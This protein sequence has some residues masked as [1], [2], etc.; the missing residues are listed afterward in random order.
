VSDRHD[1][2]RGSGEE[3]QQVAREAAAVMYQEGVDQYLEAKRIAARRI[4]GKDAGRFRPASLP[5][6][7]EIR[8]QLLALVR[9][10]EGPRQ[11]R[12]LFAMRVEA[13]V[14]MRALDAWH[15]RLLGSVWSGHVRRGS[16]IDLHVFGDLDAL[17]RDVGRLGWRATHEEVPIRV[18]GAIRLYHHLHVTDGPFPVELSV[19]APSER[20]EV[21]RSSVDGK[22]I[23]R[24]SA[25]RLA[26]RLRADSPDEFAAW[27][28]DGTVDFEEGAVPGPFDGLLADG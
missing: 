8:E 9:L 25:A 19:Y 5:S 14:R 16:D 21:T 27:E 26:A 12:R 4:L 11:E 17:V 28:R 2:R 20:R 23:D 15:P 6:N 13:L 18:S 10:A 24:V 7:G 22:P 1:R 3:R